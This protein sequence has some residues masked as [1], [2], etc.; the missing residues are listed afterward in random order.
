[1]IN[2][3]R[4]TRP[5]VGEKYGISRIAMAVNRKL[6]AR[7]IGGQRAWNAHRVTRRG[8]LQSLPPQYGI[9]PDSSETYVLGSPLCKRV[10]ARPSTFHTIQ[11][12]VLHLSLKC[13]ERRQRVKPHPQFL[14][15]HAPSTLL[16]RRS[17][18][19]G[20]QLRRR[21]AVETL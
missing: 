13:P 8:A 17:P 11:E 2:T 1:M 19:R 16:S 21:G 7:K 15:P 12:T 4:S 6:I 5:R 9:L 20:T 14:L 10:G 3:P 18:Y